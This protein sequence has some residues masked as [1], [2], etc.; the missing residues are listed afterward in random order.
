MRRRTVILKI[1]KEEKCSLGI[2]QDSLGVRTTT[3]TLPVK[4]RGKDK[5]RYGDDFIA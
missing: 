1:S 3:T 2:L 5:D 4:S